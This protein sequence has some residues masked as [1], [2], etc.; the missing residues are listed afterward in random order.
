MRQVDN[1]FQGTE[2]KYSRNDFSLFVVDPVN[3]ALGDGGNPVDQD[4]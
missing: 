3:R 1:I 2:R 4:C